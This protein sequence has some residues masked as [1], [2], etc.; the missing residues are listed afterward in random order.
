MLW[1]ATEQQPVQRPGSLASPR[2][3]RFPREGEIRTGATNRGVEVRGNLSA[4][5]FNVLAIPSPDCTPQMFRDTTDNNSVRICVS[6]RYELRIR[7]LPKSFVQQFTEDKP[8]LSYFYHQVHTDAHRQPSILFSPHSC[9]TE[10]L[11]AAS[12]LFFR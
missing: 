12:T 7:Y 8:T 6:C 3:G 11:S 1:P 9:A 4:V 5:C 2:N 10:R